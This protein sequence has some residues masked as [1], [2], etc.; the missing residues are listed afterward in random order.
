MQTHK[1]KRNSYIL[2]PKFKKKKEKYPRSPTKPKVIRKI[3]FQPG[4]M[5]QPN[6]ISRTMKQQFSSNKIYNFS[7]RRRKFITGQIY[8]GKTT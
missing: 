7:I 3:F 5:K 4:T 6:L 1:T 8:K 2:I